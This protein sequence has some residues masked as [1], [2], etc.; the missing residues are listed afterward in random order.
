MITLRLILLLLIP[1]LALSASAAAE[2]EQFYFFEETAS[3]FWAVP[4]QCADGS[5]VQATL[6]VLVTRDFE[7]P[8]TDDAEPTARVQYQAACPGGSFN[9]IGF[10]PATIT[11][12]NN[13]KSVTLPDRV[14][15]GTTAV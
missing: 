2:A 9:W 4:H 3:A 5:T 12:T 10:V 1:T 8:E 11:S 6:L 15:S 13:I 7:A 14:P